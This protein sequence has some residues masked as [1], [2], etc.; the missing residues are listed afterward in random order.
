[1]T[2]AETAIFLEGN[3]QPEICLDKENQMSKSKLKAK[4]VKAVH[5]E[6]HNMG[7]VL[8]NS[9]KKLR[10][11]ANLT[12]K[13]LAKRLS[14]GQAAVSKLE[15]RG[16]VQLSSLNQYVKALGATL[17]IEASFSSERY[18]ESIRDLSIDLNEGDQLVFPLFEE[19]PHR[20]GRDVVLSVRP[21]YSEKIVQGLKTI[22]LRRRF[23]LTA[24]KGTVAYIYSTSPVRAMIG[25]A[26]ISEVVKLPV[27]QI[28]QKFAKLAQIDRS[29]FDDYFSGLT[30]GVAIRLTKARPFSRAVALTELRDRFGFE[31]PQS[32]IYANPGLRKA[33]ENG[34]SNVSD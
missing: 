3:I 29:D 33:L 25:S 21:Q 16:D 17:R 4:V 26:Q 8:G 20:P 11:L 34:Y 24:R 19:A 30:E 15:Q 5:I 14:V 7:Q 32:F 13:E 6:K 23:P 22:E 2:Q 10:E 12:Q 1:M 18:P 28:W 31:P 9:L 27:P